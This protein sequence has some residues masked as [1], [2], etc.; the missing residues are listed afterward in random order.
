MIQHSNVE[1]NLKQV[2]RIPLVACHY[3]HSSGLHKQKECGKS[4]M[5]YPL[6]SK[7]Y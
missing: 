3:C 5:S 2:F 1:A 7:E 6:N 4:M